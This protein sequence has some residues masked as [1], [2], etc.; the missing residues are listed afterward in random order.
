MAKVANPEEIALDDEE[1][2]EGSDESAESEEE[3]ISFVPG[4]K[5][6]L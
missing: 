5:Q 2:D 6:K 1:E 4:T 3:G